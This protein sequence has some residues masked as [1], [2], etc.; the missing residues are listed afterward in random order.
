MRLRYKLAIWAVI[1]DFL[2]YLFLFQ[3]GIVLPFINPSV[4]E[5][6]Q[7][8]TSFPRNA[9]QEYV[10]MGLHVPAS[11]VYINFPFAE[12]VVVVLSLFQAGLI[13]FGIGALIE[14]L[15]NRKTA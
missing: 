12:V 15:K 10:W 1:V 2:L 5:Y 9:M 14:Y 3:S 6:S 11:L 4:T 7:Q 13:F 8:M